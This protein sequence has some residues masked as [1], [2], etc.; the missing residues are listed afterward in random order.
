MAK[1]MELPLF[2]DERGLLYVCDNMLPFQ[3]KRFY[4]FKN[5]T[6]MRGGCKHYE[7]TQAIICIQGK[8][9]V[10][11]HNKSSEDYFQLDNPTK[12]LII[13]P[14]DWHELRDFSD[15][16]IIFVLSSGSYNNNDYHFN[17]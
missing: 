14:G 4:F 16:S 11:A 7:S 8:C 2:N 5:S 1:L 15:D 17:K 12:C 6:G 9:L 10:S 13:Q 3:I